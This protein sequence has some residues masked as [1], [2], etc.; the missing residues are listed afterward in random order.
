M[1]G[2]FRL[3]AVG[4]IRS[5][6]RLLPRISSCAMVAYF[7]SAGRRAHT[8]GLAVASAC[9]LVALYAAV[10]LAGTKT[11]A[12]L[13][14]IATCGPALLYAALVAPLAFPFS[15]YAIATPFDSLLVLPEF[16]TLTRVL[17]A[18]SAAALLFYML[19]TKR[20]PQPDRA[21][22]YWLLYFLWMAASIFWAIDPAEAIGLFNI[23]IQLLLLYVIVSMFH[24][25]RA[26]LRLVAA[27]C[28]FGG[29]AAACYGIYLY[30]HG[31]A[32]LQN[33]LW[34]RSDAVNWNPDHLA[35]S[36]LLPIGIAII[37]LL[38]SRSV[39]VKAAAVPGLAIMLAAVALAGSRGAELGL[40][41]M[42]I[43]LIVRDP[44]R[45]AIALTAVLGTIGGT[46]VTHGDLFGR[47]GHTLAGGGAGRVEIW[48]VGWNAFLQNWLVGAG[49][50]N[51]KFA[52]DRVF[53]HTYQATFVDW[54]RASHNILLGTGVELGV[55]GLALLLLAWWGQF[56]LLAPIP[57]GDDRYP[58][59]LALE[60]SLIALFV[61]GMFADIM[62]EKYVWLAFMLVA[63]TRNAV[64]KG[65]TRA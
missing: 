37:A 14:L 30:M 4:S 7:R 8:I 25:D 33:R 9:G 12:A 52:Y 56:R 1:S 53:I 31:A 11:G 36:M 38:W 26:R 46:I 22:A 24:T 43:Y 29:V 5:C 49:Y 2:T 61:A 62:I 40:A 19:R 34:L 13:A 55:I 60:G 47:W 48:R 45:W 27:A 44:H 28:A 63:L 3:N 65:P 41:A 51:F 59:R 58:L 21:L 64:L 20:F 23:S 57:P 16:G 54:H 15:L 17:G 18:A 42:L 6:S 10:H 39:W 35:A 32:D 50:N